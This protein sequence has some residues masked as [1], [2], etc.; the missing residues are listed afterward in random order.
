MV[1]T[2]DP[3]LAP[4]STQYINPVGGITNIDSTLRP[5]LEN[6]KRQLSSMHVIKE[7]VIKSTVTVKK[8]S[9]SDYPALN[10]LSMDADHTISGER[11]K[12][13]NFIIDCL[14]S[15][16][17]GVTYDNNNFYVTRDYNSGKRVPMAIYVGGMPVDI[18]YLVN[19]DPKMVESVELFNTDGLSGI[20]T[21]TGTKGVLVVNTKKIPKGEKISKDQLMDLLPKNNVIEFIPGGYSAT[22]VFYSPKYDPANS[23]DGVDLRSTIYWNPG[24]ITDK[25]GNASF[26]FFNADGTGTYKAIIEG[27]DKDGN[28]GRYVYR[29][30]VQ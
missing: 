20:N 21:N 22:R 3:M 16:A 10:G 27:I 4:P 23:R 29:Y 11:I 1:L 7:V 12:D 24:V 28:I 8:A 6:S 25:N 26:D 5:Y 30:K 2:L 13:C 15:G 17:I 14:I 9:H 19:V 18:N